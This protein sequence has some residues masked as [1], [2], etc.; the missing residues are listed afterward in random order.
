[1]LV[2][3]ETNIKM[4]LIFAKLCK[5]EAAELYYLCNQKQELSWN[6]TYYLKFKQSSM[7]INI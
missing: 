6:K 1:M 2:L 4:H 5:P 7:E 3:L